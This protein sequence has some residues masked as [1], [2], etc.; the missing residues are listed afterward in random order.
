VYT[1]DRT[2]K[3]GVE[4]KNMNWR[5]GTFALAALLVAPGAPAADFP[6]DIVVCSHSRRIP[7]E[8]NGDIV[9]FGTEG[10]GIVASTANKEW[11][12]ATTR[13]VGYIRVIGGKVVGKGNCKW[14]F[15]SGDTAV[16]EWEYP[17]AG[18]PSFTWLA[19]TGKL[20]GISGGGDVPRDV[21]RQGGRPGHGA[22]LPARLG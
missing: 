6:Y 3:T 1:R 21:H 22:G 19:G 8:A 20:K 7:L 17:A 9:S 10:W 12:A 4:R 11:E 14:A 2:R 5:L 16:G 15:A 13:C 18:E